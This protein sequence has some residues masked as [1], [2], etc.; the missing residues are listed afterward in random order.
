MPGL[1][2]LFSESL[3]A[4]SYQK[5]ISPSA[6]GLLFNG[7]GIVWEKFVK[8]GHARTLQEHRLKCHI[9]QVMYTQPVLSGTA[10]LDTVFLAKREES[11][12]GIFLVTRLRQDLHEDLEEVTMARIANAGGY[13]YEFAWSNPFCVQEEPSFAFAWSNPFCV[14]ERQ[15]YGFSWSNGICAKGK[16]G[17]NLEWMD[18]ETEQHID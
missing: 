5:G 13:V 16:I 6:R 2:D 4:G 11:T 17:I 8:N 12:P 7:K 1:N 14:Q 9:D 18:I 3:Q 15:A 10:E